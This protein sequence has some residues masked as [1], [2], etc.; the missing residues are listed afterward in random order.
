[1]NSK[2]NIIPPEEW[3]GCPKPLIIA[4]PC[5]VESEKQVIDTALQLK[6]V[7]GI[8][9]FRAGLWKPRTHPGAF[10]GIENKGLPWLKKVREKTGFLIA[11]EVGHPNHI[12]FAL[13]SNIDILWIGAR[14]I[15]SP[16]VMNEIAGILKDKDIPVLIK[17]PVYPDLELW[18]G[19]IER[20]NNAGIRKIIAVHRGF[21]SYGY[22][23]YRNDPLWEIPIELKRRYPNLPLICD[24]SHISGHKQHIADISRIALDLGMEGL[25]IEVHANP[26][27]ALTDK[28]QQ[29]TPEELRTLLDKLVSPEA[30]DTSPPPAEL[31]ELRKIIDS[32]DHSILDMLAERLK[33]VESIA[34]VKRKHK[35][36]ILQV[37]TWEKKLKDWLS[38]GKD[39]DLNEDFLKTIIEQ[40]H[41]ES[42][43]RQSE[44]PDDNTQ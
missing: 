34:R 16:F 12:K 18:I 17:N 41:K 27:E 6:Q 20:M 2:L 44:L 10:E 28:Y 42:I 13:E 7:P 37:R 35:L 36:S 11:V 43:R 25:M 26:E 29:I 40:I 23:F 31:E 5:S 14:T 9:V 1:M 32:I 19:A 4:G 33:T 22:S 24:P 38:K 30:G 8:S 39:L 15:V 21:H 3:C